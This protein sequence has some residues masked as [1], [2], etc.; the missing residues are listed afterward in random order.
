MLEH[1]STVARN[2]GSGGSHNPLSICCC[3]QKM[4]APRF[5]H[6]STQQML[7]SSFKHSLLHTNPW[8]LIPHSISLQCSQYVGWKKVRRLKS[9]PMC[10]C[11]GLAT[12]SIVHKQSTLKSM[13]MIWCHV[14]NEKLYKSR[15][16]T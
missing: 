8:P 3:T 6:A 14:T 12:A 5:L 15:R 2:N 9:W 16:L 10:R 4:F 11:I 7:C 1:S 13:D